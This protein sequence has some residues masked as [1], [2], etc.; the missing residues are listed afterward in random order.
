[1]SDR[2][3]RN[4]RKA[5]RRM[6]KLLREAMA[7]PPPPGFSLH[8]EVADFGRQLEACIQRDSDGL[9][10]GVAAVA[11][12]LWRRMDAVPAR[13]AARLVAWMNARQ[14]HPL[15]NP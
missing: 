9:R 1:M 8:F 12:R 15:D 6:V 11:E 5:R 3:Q 2:Q 13:M 14:S 10:C 7:L 4:R